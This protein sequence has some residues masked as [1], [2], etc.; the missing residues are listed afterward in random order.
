MNISRKGL[1]MLIAQLQARYLFG[2]LKFL[3]GT[4]IEKVYWNP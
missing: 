2:C 1:A 3:R 4:R